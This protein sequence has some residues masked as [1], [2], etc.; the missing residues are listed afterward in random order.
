MTYSEIIND[1]TPVLVDFSAEWCGPCK[2]MH[3]VLQKVAS[4]I[5]EDGRIIKIDVDKNRNLAS[6]MGVMGVP[7]FI[8]YKE[9]KILWRKSGMQSET[10]LTKIIKEAADN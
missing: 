5:G 2:A 8:L 7:T 4:N 9:G 10:E 6:K 1:T 3:P